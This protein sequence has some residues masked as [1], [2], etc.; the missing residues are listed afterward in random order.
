MHIEFDSRDD[1]G[2]T[3]LRAV[4]EPDDRA[5]P[6]DQLIFDAEP[7]TLTKDR[8]AI[9]GTLA[10][11]AYAGGR[12]GFPSKIS[13]AAEAAIISATGLQVSTG[14]SRKAET[15][16]KDEP[17]QATTLT[18]QIA[19]SLPASTP[20][21]DR[22]V[23]SLVQDARYS[24]A[25]FGVKESVIASNAWYASRR[26]DAASVLAAAGVLFAQDLLAREIDLALPGSE[27]AGLS[28]TVRTLCAA[29]GLSLQ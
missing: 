13:S 6:V 27:S 14:V 18:V 2:R 24:G 16:P 28:S 29:V 19:E 5:L 11:G 20:G 21:V 10:F 26:L 17:L 25:L 7:R 12:I 4:R 22:T 1:T 15:A 8:I 23:L 9:A 3:R